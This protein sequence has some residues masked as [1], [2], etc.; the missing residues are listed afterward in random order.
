MWYCDS[1]FAGSGSDV[2]L[3]LWGVVFHDHMPN[4]QTDPQSSAQ[5]DKDPAIG[6]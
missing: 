1:C 5:L 4:D 2:V 6:S 3:T